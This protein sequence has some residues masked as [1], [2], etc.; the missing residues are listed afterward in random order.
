MRTRTLCRIRVPHV[1]TF[2]EIIYAY[3]SAIRRYA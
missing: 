1:R 3:V 2:Q